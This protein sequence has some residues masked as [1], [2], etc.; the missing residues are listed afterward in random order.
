MKALMAIFAGAVMGGFLLLALLLGLQRLW[1]GWPAATLIIALVCF[2]AFWVLG[3]LAWARMADARGRGH[4]L[5]AATVGLG[6]PRCGHA[7]LSPLRKWSLGRDDTAQCRHCGETL[8]NNDFPFVVLWAPPLLSL[9]MFPLIAALVP[10]A[11]PV[12]TL[13]W[14][15][16]AGCVVSVVMALTRSFVLVKPLAPVESPSLAQVPTT[17][18]P[19]E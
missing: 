17:T 5:W 15:L 14:L 7:A 6:C 3:G 16:G 10:G 11:A 4:S 1:G 9:L 18:A 2:P 8:T 19:E 12:S 13:L